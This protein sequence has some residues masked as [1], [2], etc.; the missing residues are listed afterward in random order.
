M[1][2][3]KKIQTLFT[4]KENLTLGGFFF[5]F[6]CSV[7]GIFYIESRNVWNRGSFVSS[8]SC[9]NA[10][11]FLAFVHWLEAPSNPTLHK[12]GESGQPCL[13]LI[14]RENIQSFT[15]KYTMLAV[16]FCI[17]IIREVCL[18]FSYFVLSLFGYGIWTILTSRNKLGGISFSCFMDEIG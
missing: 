15:V 8:F 16:G 7:L 4:Q 18:P 10:L 14:Y 11:Y 5:F 1:A 6:F 12:D 2:F 3:F 17:Y 13:I 9:M